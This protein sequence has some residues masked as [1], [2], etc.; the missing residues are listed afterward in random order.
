MSVQPAVYPCATL[1]H[2]NADD[3]LMIEPTTIAHTMVKLLGLWR[4][5]Q[6]AAL[7]QAQLAK[8]SGLQRSTIA[9][10]EAGKEAYPTTVRKLADALGCTPRELIDQP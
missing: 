2:Y 10:L 6:L 3:A 1:G 8:R 5:R 7:T 4:Q 9:N